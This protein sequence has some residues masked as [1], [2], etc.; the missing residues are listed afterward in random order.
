MKKSAKP[1][2]PAVLRFRHFL[3]LFGFLS[4]AVLLSVYFLIFCRVQTVSVENTDI[5]TEQAVLDAVDIQAGRHLYAVSEAKIERAVMKSSPYVKS[6]AIKRDLPS[7]L[8]ILVEEYELAYYIE[9]EERYYLITDDFLVLEETTPEKA[10][11]KGA[12]LLKLPKLKDPKPPADDPDAPKVLTPM[13]TLTFAVKADKAWSLTL[14]S[15]IREMEISKHIT[16][17]D[18]AD[19]FD[20][21]LQI[22]DKYTVLLG[23]ERDFEKKLLRAKRALAYLSESAYGLTG[24]LHAQKDAPITFEFTGVI[25]NVDS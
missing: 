1:I 6:V 23:N 14:L 10:A 4:V 13:E 2:T 7:T 20:L 9:Y 16:E 17:I 19:P 18:I 5:L 22:A 8:R 21:H 24:V 3:I 12:V 15:A 11:A 25:E